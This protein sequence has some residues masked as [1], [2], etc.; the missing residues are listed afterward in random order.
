MENVAKHT[1]GEDISKSHLDVFDAERGDAKSSENTISEFRGFAKWLGKFEITRVVYEPTR[2][3][4]RNFGECFCDKL[5]LVKVNTRQAHQFAEPCGTRVKTD[6]IDARGLARMGV[7][8]ELEPDI[9]VAKTIR[10][11]R[12]LKVARGLD[13]RADALQQPRTCA[14]NAILKRQTKARLTVIEKQL[15]GINQ[16]IDILIKADKTSECRCE[17]VQS[18][19]GLDSVASAAILT[20][21]PKVGTLDCR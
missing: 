15:C 4:H 8:L 7:A 2:P 21:L 20:Y 5:T 13:Q 16:E 9:P 3:Y 14:T 6:A 19:P 11:L 12:N 1:I 17:I 18:I 10:I